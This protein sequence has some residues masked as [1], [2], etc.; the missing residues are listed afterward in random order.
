MCSCTCRMPRWFTLAI[1]CLSRLA[2]SASHAAFKLLRFDIFTQ[3]PAY[4]RIARIHSPLISGRRCKGTAKA[5][6]KP[7][8]HQVRV[9]GTGCR[10]SLILREKK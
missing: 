7:T 9:V 1:C 6:K 3:L 2:W 10:I 5:Q 4:L 8:T